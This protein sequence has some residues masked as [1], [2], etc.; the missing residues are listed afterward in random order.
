MLSGRKKNSNGAG[1]EHDENVTF[2]IRIIPDLTGLYWLIITVKNTE[3]N[4]R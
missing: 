2:I 3:N 4:Y 1:F